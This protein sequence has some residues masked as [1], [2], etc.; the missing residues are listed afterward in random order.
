MSSQRRE[1][2]WQPTSCT[3]RAVA[4]GAPGDGSSSLGWSSG[5]PG[6]GSSSQG[7]KVLGLLAPAPH[8]PRDRA[9]AMVGTAPPQA[10]VRLQATWLATNFLQSDHLFAQL[11]R[12]VEQDIRR[13]SPPPGDATRPVSPRSSLP[14]TPSPSVLK[15]LHPTLPQLPAGK[16][17]WTE[18]YDGKRDLH[19]QHA[20]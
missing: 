7:W 15:R 4:S 5:A 19:L 17:R 10:I 16:C 14:L 1:N 12:L 18:R 3:E 20:A 6:D 2:R 9:P 13:G 8:A 11:V